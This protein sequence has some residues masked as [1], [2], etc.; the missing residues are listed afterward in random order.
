MASKKKAQPL[1]FFGLGGPAHWLR[2]IL[3]ALLMGIQ[4]YLASED[5]SFSFLQRKGKTTMYI[6][7]NNKMWNLVKNHFSLTWHKGNECFP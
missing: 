2:T 1:S 5:G 3:T 6:T 4:L 7:K